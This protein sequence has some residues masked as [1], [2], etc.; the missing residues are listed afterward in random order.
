MACFLPIWGERELHDSAA[1]H[2]KARIENR[3]SSPAPGGFDKNAD[4]AYTGHQDGRVMKMILT[5]ID[6]GRPNTTQRFGERFDQVI[7]R[8][9]PNNQRKVLF[10]EVNHTLFIGLRKPN[11]SPR[12]S[13]GVDLVERAKV[14]AWPTLARAE[15]GC[16][17]ARKRTFRFT[18]HG[19]D[20]PHQNA[21]DSTRAKIAPPMPPEKNRTGHSWPPLGA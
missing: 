16:A 3:P 8:H 10:M 14:G 5:E 13:P 9:N 6:E 4:F 1:A 15:K 2:Q 18:G 17:G 21:E 7:Y 20:A 11:P 19:W 12:W